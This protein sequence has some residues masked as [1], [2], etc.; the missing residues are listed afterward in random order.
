MMAKAKDI[1]ADVKERLDH[2]ADEAKADAAEGASE[3]KD[4]FREA[5]DGVRDHRRGARRPQGP[6]SPPPPTALTGWPDAFVASGQLPCE[7]AWGEPGE[8]P[9]LT[10]SV[11]GTDGSQPGMPTDFCCIRSTAGTCGGA[12]A[13]TRRWVLFILDE[14]TET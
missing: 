6:L 4:S 9:G 13:A 8:S 1:A 12:P 11:M 10:R 5:A 3:A 2:D 7:A 14:R